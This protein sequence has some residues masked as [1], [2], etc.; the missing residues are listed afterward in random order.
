VTP[1]RTRGEGQRAHYAAT[2]DACGEPIRKG[3]PIA[4]RGG[5]WLHR[6]CAGRG[7]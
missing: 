6:A 2:C 3:D 5:A 7:E 1:V 4:T